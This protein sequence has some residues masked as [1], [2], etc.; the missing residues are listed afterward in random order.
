MVVICA[1]FKEGDQIFPTFLVHRIPWLTFKSKNQNDGRSLETF[2]INF[3]LVHWKMA[4]TSTGQVASMT[5]PQHAVNGKLGTIGPE[6]QCV[7]GMSLHV[8]VP[9]KRVVP[10][11]HQPPCKPLPTSAQWRW[12]ASQASRSL[13]KRE[14]VS[15][16]I[17]WF[18]APAALCLQ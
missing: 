17:K 8:H 6:P 18:V 12:H 9:E 7:I 13:D 2:L 1:E 4:S 16:K 14:V 11:A 3:C 15:P 5:A 10:D